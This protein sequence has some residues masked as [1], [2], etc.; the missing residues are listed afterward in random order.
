MERPTLQ[1]L[2]YLVALADEGH[3]GR[4]ARASHVT[5][6]AL[7][8][9]IRELERRIGATLVER[10]PRGIR[11]T[12]D[13]AAAV[14]RARR[15]LRDVDELLEEAT[16]SDGE[17]TGPVVLGVIPTAAPYVLG[18]LVPTL[19]NR[20]PGAEVRLEELHTES[21]LGR[22]RDGRVDLALCA[23]PVAGDDLT[24]AELATDPFLLAVPGD[25][26]LARGR[27]P[28]SIDVLA[29]LRVLLLSDGHCLRDQA[30]AVCDR[31]GTE[32]TDASATSLPTLVQMVAAGGG[33]TLLPASAAAVEARPGNGIGVRRFREPVART[34]GFV[35]RR[36]SP[37][38]AAYEELVRLARPRLRR[39][40]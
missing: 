36:S 11:F 27:G 4:A 30:L 20:F 2:A 8:S 23:L 34:L 29:D 16:A 33:V 25:H 37:R 35:W 17:L 19:T 12:P 6:P 24:T 28:V 13:G 38:R 22:L 32:P 31:V 5:Q 26:A 18:A 14:L 15:V 39:S 21:L 3:F 10:L 7:S 9:Q 1:Q 40:P